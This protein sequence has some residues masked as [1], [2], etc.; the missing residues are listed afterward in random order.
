MT[1]KK[2][3]VAHQLAVVAK[4]VLTPVMFFEM[5]PFRVVTVAELAGLVRSMAFGE[6]SSELDCRWVVFLAKDAE[7][8]LSAHPLMRGQMCF[9]EKFFEAETARVYLK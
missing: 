7:V 1:W 6:V 3:E 5:L 9:I 8:A 4:P 2:R